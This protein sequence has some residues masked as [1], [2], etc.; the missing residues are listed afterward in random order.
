MTWNTKSC[1]S[2]QSTEIT[3]EAIEN[4]CPQA[5]QNIYNTDDTFTDNRTGELNDNFFRLLNTAT[6]QFF[7]IDP[8]TGEFRMQ[9]GSGAGSSEGL[10]INTDNN[11]ET[12]LLGRER[13][14]IANSSNSNDFIEVSNGCIRLPIYD[15]T[16]RQIIPSTIIAQNPSTGCLEW[17]FPQDIANFT[18]DNYQ[19]N[20]IIT[21][22]YSGTVLANVGGQIREVPTQFL[23]IPEKQVLTKIAA[24]GQTLVIGISDGSTNIAFSTI[25]VQLAKTFTTVEKPFS[26]GV[27]INSNSNI[28]VS[29]N[30]TTPFLEG[31]T[32]TPV[33][34]G[35]DTILYQV[36]FTTPHPD[37][38]Q[39]TPIV[40]AISNEPTGIE[41]VA[42]VVEG[43]ITA[44]GFDV[45]TTVG[46]N[47]GTEDVQVF[48][49]FTFKVLE[50]VQVLTDVNFQ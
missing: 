2:N 11:G 41:A 21:T 22:P 8:T 23:S 43:S 33:G 29:T 24:V 31:A 3:C 27:V 20:G 47:G 9:V 50:K 25:N 30:I 44:N 5:L 38:A 32:V 14:L 7:L 42:S 16:K 17:T 49:N 37:L 40:S 46:D 34:N 35:N 1:C 36:R 39:Y 4:A 48:L 26:Q 15:N 19:T 18:F 6:G 13:V 45:I 10:F 28:L 12:L